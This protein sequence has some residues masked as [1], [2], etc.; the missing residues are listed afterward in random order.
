MEIDFKSHQR[1]ISN[2][3]EIKIVWMAKT[4]KTKKSIN[5]TIELLKNKIPSYL[6]CTTDISVRKSNV[7]TLRR[8]F[9]RIR[10]PM[11]KHLEKK[12]KE[13]GAP[14]ERKRVRIKVTRIVYTCR[15][16]NN[17]ER[18]NRR[19]DEKNQAKDK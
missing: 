1:Q 3:Y 13:C 10:T 14:F 19:Y 17:I 12:C 4:K 11:G 5:A 9:Q 16:C 2:E 6:D 18:I 7:L 15:D 8:T